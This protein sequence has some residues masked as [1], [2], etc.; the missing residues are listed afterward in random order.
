MVGCIGVKDNS[1][2]V[3]AKKTVSSSES[4]Q[5]CSLLV[6]S[7]CCNDAVTCLTRLIS[8]IQL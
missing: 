2:M 5:N 1:Y 3:S 4:L 7:D 8:T 6:A